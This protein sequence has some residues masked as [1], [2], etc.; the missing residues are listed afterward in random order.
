MGIVEFVLAR[1]FMGDVVYI[2]S[3]NIKQVA[4]KLEKQYQK[5]IFALSDN[6]VKAVESSI[7]A[8]INAI[9]DKL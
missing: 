1:H 9:F 2:K 8:E 6:D 5:T 7:V 3:S 4:A